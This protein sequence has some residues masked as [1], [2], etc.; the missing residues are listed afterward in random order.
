MCV[1]RYLGKPTFAPSPQP[2][3]QPS[4]T[5]SGGLQPQSRSHPDPIDTPS[6]CFSRQ[7]APSHSY[8][9]DYS[10]P[11][12]ST[13]YSE[14]QFDQVASPPLFSTP[15][16]GRR[17][18]FQPVWRRPS[19]MGRGDP[20][21]VPDDRYCVP[22]PAPIAAVSDPYN[23][24]A[25]CA[26]PPGPFPGPTAESGFSVPRYSLQRFPLA[27]PAISANYNR[28]QQSFAGQPQFQAVESE[29]IPP[30][31]AR[32]CENYWP[33]AQNFAGGRREEPLTELM[34][35]RPRGR[36]RGGAYYQA[37]KELGGVEDTISGLRGR[38]DMI[39]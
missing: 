20:F 12:R 15:D 38:S 7:S 5:P 25:Y 2:L 34:R 10:V 13:A 11:Q 29:F 4:L 9:R 14:R 35:S 26:P 1:G 3:P 33:D 19:S 23:N 8:R 17:A 32:T 39:V 31:Q 21:A 36:Q 18:D 28:Y 6:F 16:R 37:L 24:N 27:E 30:A 22:P